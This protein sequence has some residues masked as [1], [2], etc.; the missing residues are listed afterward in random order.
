MSY[1]G[2]YPSATESIKNSSH[3]VLRI[4]ELKERFSNR[5][6]L[7]VNFVLKVP[8]PNDSENATGATLPTPNNRSNVTLLY[9]AED[10]ESLPD[11]MVNIFDSCANV[12]FQV[13]RPWSSMEFAYV[14]AAI[15]SAIFDQ[16]C[17]AVCDDEVSRKLKD[18]LM[19]E[20]D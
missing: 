1:N 5:G 2:N 8:H 4:L 10:L 3:T 18:L 19:K 6:L 15:L 16:P 13:F 20:S 12:V 11:G 9:N 7:D 14:K 17:Q